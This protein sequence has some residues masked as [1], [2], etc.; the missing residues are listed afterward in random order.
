MDAT[1]YSRETPVEYCIRRCRGW[2]IAGGS[3]EILKNRIAEEI[4]DRRFDQRGKRANA[5]E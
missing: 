3:V 1:G 5:A 2:M 4:F